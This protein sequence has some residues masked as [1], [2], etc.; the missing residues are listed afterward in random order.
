MHYFTLTKSLIRGDRP[1]KINSELRAHIG[2]TPLLDSLCSTKDLKQF[3]IAQLTSLCDEVGG[4]FASS[5]GV[6]ELTVALH[7]VFNTPKDRIVWDVGHQAYIHKIL[8][9]RREEMSTVR[10]LGGISGFP[11]RMESDYDTFGVAHAGT[12]I[13]AALG[14]LEASFH[15]YP[16]SEERNAVAVIGDGAMTAGMAFEALNHSGHLHRKLIVILNDNEMSIAPNV[17][18]LSLAFS[19]TLTSNFST[20]ARKHFKNLVQK[21]LIPKVFYRALDRAEEA[22]QGFFSTPAMLFESFGYRYIGP[23]DGHNLEQLIDAL[24]R[25][26]NQDG[27]VLIHALTV[28]GKGYEP[29]EEDPVKYHAVNANS[30]FDANKSQTTNSAKNQ[31]YTEV[32]GKALVDLCKA[33]PRVVGITAAMPDGT[34]LTYLSEQMPERYFDV[35]IAEQH[36]VTFAAGLACEGMRPFCAIYSTFLQRAF[37]QI[38]HDVCIQSIPVIFA[39]DRGGLVGADGPT[40]HGVFDLG[41]LRILPNM[42]IMVPKDDIELRDMMHTAVLHETG[43][44]AFRYP[45]GSVKKKVGDE[46]PTKPEQIQIGKAEIISLAKEQNKI[47]LVGLG[48]TVAFASDAA[49]ELEKFGVHCSVV[50]AR[51]VKPLDVELFTELASSHQLIV[52]IED[53]ATTGGFGTA[54]LEC[55]S[56]AGKLS[57]TELLRLGIGDFFVEHG[58]QEQLYSICEFDVKSIVEKVLAK[59]SHANNA[60]SKDSVVHCA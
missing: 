36:A 28:K 5:L 20:T 44:I 6:T 29:A 57:E 25:A 59:V 48:N 41:Y 39:M 33:D 46:N 27:P 17:G 34:G 58:T 7:K 9:G 2:E 47:L 53:H 16:G 3:S 32:F 49:I 40:H 15:Q 22:A 1:L 45:R 54:V 35:G 37:D 60:N 55:L 10:Q 30:L 56:D 19:K 13:S 12:S 38:V 11:R 52:T 24:E 43:P 50:N 26:K 51:F 23:V 14:M 31:S 18:A 21:G 42:T 4:H 8:T